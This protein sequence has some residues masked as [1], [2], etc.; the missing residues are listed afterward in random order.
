MSALSR[1]FWLVAQLTMQWKGAYPIVLYRDIRLPALLHQS[2]A[3]HTLL[4]DAHFYLAFALFA[5]ILSMSQQRCSTRSFSMTACSRAWRPRPR[6]TRRCSDPRR[7]KPVRDPMADVYVRFR[8][9]N[10]FG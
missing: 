8:E 10:H 6:T 4:W 3:M 5:I 2:D 9:T 1:R 7:M